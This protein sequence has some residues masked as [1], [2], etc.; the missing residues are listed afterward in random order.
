MATMLCVPGGQW[1]ED[2]KIV[3]WKAFAGTRVI[4]QLTDDGAGGAPPNEGF[5]GAGEAWLSRPSGAEP[6]SKLTVLEWTPHCLKVAID[7][8]NPFTGM[9]PD[10]DARPEDPRIDPDE[11]L[12]IKVVLTQGPT[13]SAWLC[14]GGPEGSGYGPPVHSS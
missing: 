11:P 2:R 12:Q 8:V 1:E 9:E 3:P 4:L 13:Y 5:G 7:A 10:P 14:I 6:D